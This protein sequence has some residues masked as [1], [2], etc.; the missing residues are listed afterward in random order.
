MKI[1]LYI[2]HGCIVERRY[3]EMVYRKAK[4]R[5]DQANDSDGHRDNTYEY[6]IAHFE[7]SATRL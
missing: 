1:L 3:C 7:K 2:L 5:G 6:A 4:Q